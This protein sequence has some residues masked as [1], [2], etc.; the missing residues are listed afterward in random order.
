MAGSRAGG[1][2]DG[3]VALGRRGEVA[4]AAYLESLG[5]RVLERNWRCRYGELDLVAEH[6]GCLVVVEVKTRSGTGYGTGFEAITW[7]KLARLRRLTGLWLQAHPGTGA[8]QVRLDVV[9]VMVGRDD[10]LSVQH[11][12]GVG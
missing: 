2:V 7:R 5:M 1:R 11:L 4:A 9:V 6:E 8:G 10:A 12:A 3:R